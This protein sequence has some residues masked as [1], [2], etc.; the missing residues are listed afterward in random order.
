MENGL[1][2]DW[3]WHPAA[4]Y[5]SDTLRFATCFSASYGSFGSKDV[6]VA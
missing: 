3:G 5:F 2:P 6:L 4:R 1:K